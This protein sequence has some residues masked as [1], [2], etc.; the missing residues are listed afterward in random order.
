MKNKRKKR[1]RLSLSKL[2]KLFIATIV[3]GYFLS[4]VT[5]FFS[6]A[7]NK[8]YIAEYGKIE[9]AVSTEGYIVRDEKVMKN[10][11]E[12][13]VVLYVSEGEKV[14]RNQKLAEI[15]L[16]EID[17]KTSKDLEIIN[18]RIQNIKEQQ[19]EQ[20]VFSKDIEKIDGEINA[21]LKE[22][23]Q[24]INEGS[25]ERVS[26]LKE[27]LSTLVEKKSVI[28]GEKS[29]S[30][31]NLDQLE[32]QQQSLQ[33]K[34]NASVEVVYSEFPGVFAIGND[35]L[36]ELL[37]LK[38]IENITEQEW[39]TIKNTYKPKS[40]ALEQNS[41]RIIENHR[42][43]I[44]AKLKEVE[45]EGI[46][47]NR[48]VMIRLRGDSK[49]YRATVRKIIEVNEEEIIVILDLTDFIEDFYNK[50]L[51]AFDMIKSSFEGIMIP[52]SAIVEREG[53][54]GIYRLDVNGFARFIPIKV[55]GS[56]REYSIVYYGSFDDTKDGET[57]RV[58][59]MNFYDEIVVNAQHISE[60]EKIR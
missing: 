17:A 30:G 28:S 6:Q 52:N 29:F 34:I 59:T 3:L 1:R 10:L 16:E 40:D 22:V 31:K 53:R 49:E 39:Q 48:R 32:K 5:P 33:S 23:Q 21:I 2:V 35:G 24:H 11:G 12:G 14:A 42:W 45:I 20:Q 60:G 55:K 51:I 50:R 27:N 15:Y 7:T 4:R 8:T 26:L 9:A 54:E 19:S 47:E 56:N 25:Y 13:K 58:N 37:N 57:K 41:L 36:E 18:L 44:V 38:N 46:G 43:S